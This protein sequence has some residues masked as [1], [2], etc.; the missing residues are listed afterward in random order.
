MELTDFELSVLEEYSAGAVRWQFAEKIRRN[1]FPEDAPP[2]IMIAF[3]G[4]YIAKTVIDGESVWAA[5]SK[6]KGRFYYTEYADT[7][8]SLLAGL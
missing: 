6:H 3:G 5:V 7:L 8:E 2:E 4:T 1:K